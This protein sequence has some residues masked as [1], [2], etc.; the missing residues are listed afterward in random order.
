MYWI[1][2]LRTSLLIRWKRLI[3]RMPLRRSA[4]YSPFVI[5]CMPRSGSTLLHT[6]LNSHPRIFSYD[7]ILRIRFEQRGSV[8][9]EFI[10][11][12]I[13]KPYAKHFQA[14]GLKV[15]YEYERQEPFV[16]SFDQITTN[17]TIKIIHLT[18]RDM[19]RQFVSLKQAESSGEWSAPSRPKNQTRVEL[20]TVEFLNY[21][22]SAFK[23]QNRMREL[24]K[25][26]AILEIAY[27]DLTKNPPAILSKVQSFLGVEGRSLYSLLE[28]Q[29]PESLE[30]L[31]SNYES[32][33]E[34]MMQN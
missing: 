32:V 30:D 31:V 5:L 26:H 28:K 21:K 1:Q 6:Y 14:I 23:D 12:K 24:F 34:F 3:M 13:F 11:S 10:P 22:E 2:H 29:N 25:D 16:A 4:D 19:L 7:E 33:K 18:R 15:F 17:K 20:N 9:D 27:E 8:E